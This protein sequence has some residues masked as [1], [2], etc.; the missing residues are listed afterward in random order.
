MRLHSGAKFAK[1]HTFFRTHYC[2]WLQ[3]V[4][5]VAGTRYRFS[6][7]IHSWYSACSS[8][9]HSIPLLDDCITPA[10]DSHNILQVGIG[11]GGANQSPLSDQI[12]WS[13]PT[14]IYGRY[15]DPISVEAIAEG[16]TVTVWIRTWTNY[17]LKHEDVYFDDAELIAIDPGY[18]Y[19]RYAVLLPQSATVEEAAETMRMHYANRR[20]ITFS[21]DDVANR[22]ERCTRVAVE[23]IRPQ[24]WGGR[25]ALL[26]HWRTY[27][28]EPDEVIWKGEP[29]PPNPWLLAQR[30]PRWANAPFGDAN[31]HQTIGQ[32]GCFITCLA[33][34]QRFYGI[35][36][37]AT[38]VT[39]DMALGPAG[40]WGCI[41]AWGASAA[42]YRDKLRLAI[43]NATQA[44]AVA[45]IQAGGCALIEVMPSTTEHFIL[46]TE[47]EQDTQSVYVLDPWRN[48]ARWMPL[49]EAESWRI[50]THVPPPV[51]Q[52]ARVGLHIQ[53]S[54][55]DPTAYVVA[56]G[57]PIKFLAGIED[58]ISVKRARRDAFC[59][60]RQWVPEQPIATPDK[61][62]L[63]REYVNR[64]RDSMEHVCAV[65][66]ADGF[67][68]PYFGVEG[69]N[70]TYACWADSIPDAIEC[71]RSFI[72]ALAGYPVAP[73]V[74]CAAVGNIQLPSEDP[75]GTAWPH[76]AVLAMETQ[77]AQ[78]CFGLHTYWFANPSESGLEAH[79]PWLA[80]RWIQFDEY[81]VNQHHIYVD[82]FFG[83]CGAVGGR[84]LPG[85]G[86]ELNAHSGWKDSQCYAGN[87]S[88][89]VTDLVTFSDKV[90]TWNET[91][92]NRAQG[93]TIFTTTGG[94]YGW[95]SFEIGPAEMRSLA[96]ALT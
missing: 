43:S 62:R 41:A 91:H 55:G 68:P 96:A 47:Y 15:A 8:K 88:R 32:V 5:I 36:A 52:P 22:E 79:W 54:V 1:L 78:G 77:V 6:A 83:E 63:M 72:R 18:T 11:S 69:Y 53:R 66:S 87:W 94:G 45:H 58:I 39:V 38:P 71:D 57:G 33:M 85:G 64:F 34:A 48:E 95:D 80:G 35:N 20:T 75:N 67:V 90:K 30:D 17:A 44:Q 19:E 26:N 31:C 73:I 93:G 76:L 59:V 2:G 10:S 23:V 27:F 40:Y 16:D 70:E 61:D 28:E 51:T 74:F 25:E 89:Y 14:E 81:L 3:E 9:P 7:Y 42:L 60:W 37:E 12:V 82:W 86:Y 46:A 92:G 49:V 21:A 13:A 56:T 84:A 24:D 65:L 50:V 29:P 4:P